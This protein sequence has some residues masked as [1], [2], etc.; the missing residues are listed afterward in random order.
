MAVMHQESKFDAEAKPPR[1]TCLCIFPGPRPSSAYGYAQALDE[2]W[3]KYKQETGN[4]G[5]DRDNFADSIDFIGW[6]CN[7][8]RKL[9]GI[10]PNDAYSLYLAYHE[11][12]NGFKRKTYKRKKWL[13]QVAGKVQRRAK[14]YTRQLA[15]CKSEFQKGRGC[16]LW[17]F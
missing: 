14:T 11:G 3:D 6:Y 2:T 9:C 1:T 10:S 4:W 16:C 7:L 5:A 12:H 13:Q 8:S 15:S 17:P